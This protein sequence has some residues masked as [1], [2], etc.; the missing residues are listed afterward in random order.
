MLRVRTQSDFNL[1]ASKEGVASSFSK[2]GFQDAIA[3]PRTPTT[4]SH[5]LF[6]P[7]RRIDWA[8]IRG[9]LRASGKV[10]SQVRASDH[11]PIS[12]TLIASRG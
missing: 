10:H 6:E 11:Y 4:P 8:F 7:G 12:F 5:R 3:A 2:A 9:P 1:D